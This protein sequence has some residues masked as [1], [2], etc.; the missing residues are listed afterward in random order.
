MGRYD[1]I[2]YHSGSGY[3]QPMECYVHNGTSWVDFG[4]NTD[5]A[6]PSNREIY[7]HNGTGWV[8]KT[9]NGKKYL[10]MTGQNGIQLGNIYQFYKFHFEME[11]E[12]NALSKQMIFESYVDGTHYARVGLYDN[13]GF[14]YIYF[15]AQYGNYV[16]E[17]STLYATNK[18]SIKTGTKY[19]I[20]MDDTSG[21]MNGTVTNMVSNLIMTIRTSGGGTGYSL[22]GFYGYSACKSALFGGSQITDR[23]MK[24]K[25][26]S[27]KIATYGM[28]NGFN[29]G[30]YLNNNI[31]IGSNTWAI[32]NPQGSAKALN[33]TGVFTSEWY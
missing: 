8:K 22:A 7:V 33:V 2:K 30:E 19:K 1:K 21:S 6:G 9:L 17:L 10:S 31:I 3:I 13:N 15:K 24:A 11:V 5:I 26:Y 4:A 14:W 27:C 18:E 20:I 25:I 16:G 29:G 23:P 28:T 32:T 12:F